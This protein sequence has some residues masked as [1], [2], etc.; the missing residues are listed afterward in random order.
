MLL[1]NTIDADSRASHPFLYARVLGIYHVNVVYTGE[2][3]VN[4][5][6]HRV[7]FLWVR[8]FDYGGTKSL[9][10]DD[11]DLDSVSFLPME[12]EHAFGFVD[13]Q[14][15]L[16]GCHI[17]PTFSGGRLH[18]DGVGL[19]RCAGDALDWARYRVNR[20]VTHHRII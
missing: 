3:M 8:W 10:W 11:H 1:A 13:P 14:D 19:S 5:D 18:L 12:N 16:R 20:L 4:Y 6:A 17:I 2:G 7:Y 15:V 9:G